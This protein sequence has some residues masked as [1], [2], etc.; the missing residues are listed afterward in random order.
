MKAHKI[1]N[2]TFDEYLKQEETS[3]TKYEFHDGKIFS[4][5]GGTV[6]HGKICGNVYTEL[7]NGL[8]AKQSKCLTY[9]SDVKLFIK[10]SNSYVYPDTMVICDENDDKSNEH[11]VT[12]PILIV[13]VLSKSTSGYDRGDKFYLYRQLDSLEEYVLIEQDKYIVD[14]HFKKKES[15]LWS[16]TRYKGIDAMVKF[17]SIDVAISMKD[18]YFSTDIVSSN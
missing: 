16:I 4:L 1:P 9:N 7:R 8:K 6:N 12:N 11:S 3:N 17:Q 15:D 14:I 13:E 10:P 5:A 2:L 18:L